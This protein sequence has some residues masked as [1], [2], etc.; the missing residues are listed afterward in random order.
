MLFR[1]LCGI[2]AHAAGLRETPAPVAVVDLI[3]DFDWRRVP[4]ADRVARWT[5]AGLVVE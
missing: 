3:A 1:S 5:A 2:L 4:A